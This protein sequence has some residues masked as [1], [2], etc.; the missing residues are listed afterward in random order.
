MK[1]YIAILRGINVSGKKRILMKDLIQL[2]QTA[3]FQNIQTYVQSGN[4]I[5]DSEE[6]SLSDLEA[7]FENSISEKYGFEASVIIIKP[8]KLQSIIAENP[9][10]PDQDTIKQNYL[11]FLKEAPVL[12]R[13]EELNSSSFKDEFKVN[14]NHIYVKYN[15]K[16]SDSKLDNNFFERKLKVPASTRNWK[17]VLKL[18]S[19]I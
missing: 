16:Y 9:F 19:M 5:F 8:E 6:T 2:L 15:T 14:Q 11:V 7:R 1:T 3:G 10:S 4:V 17:T 13:I 12:E 18:S